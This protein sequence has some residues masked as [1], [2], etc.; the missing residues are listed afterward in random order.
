[1]IAAME[2]VNVNQKT[3]KQKFDVLVQLFLVENKN[4]W[5]NKDFGREMAACKRLIN[6]YPDFEFFYFLPEF[7]NKFNSL[8]GLT[9]KQNKT[10]LDIKYKEWQDKKS[11]EIKLEDKPVIQLE[12]TEK[13]PKNILE[14]LNS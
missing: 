6:Y 2:T 3:F 1:M 5:E 11:N 10:I 7:N 4:K 8:L 14:F 9:S 12:F 13:K